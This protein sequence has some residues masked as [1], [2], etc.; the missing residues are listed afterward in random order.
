ME[1]KPVPSADPIK[2]PGNTPPAN[3]GKEPDIQSPEI[4]EAEPNK[5]PEGE[6]KAKEV[7]EESGKSKHEKEQLR[8]RKRI[9]EILEEYGGV[10]SNIPLSHEYWGLAGQLETFRQR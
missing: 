3:L 1:H 8:I 6:F 10:R 9:G 5:V 2:N 7:P 4:K